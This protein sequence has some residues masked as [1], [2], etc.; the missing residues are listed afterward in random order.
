LKDESIPDKLADGF[1][2][3]YK[4]LY[5]KY[6]VDELYDTLFVNRIKGLGTRLARFDL[7]V[8]DG[9]VNGSAW[10]TRTI[11][12]ISGFFDYWFVDGAVRSSAII[13]YLS[14]PVRWLQTGRIQNYFAMAL[15]GMLLLT[16]YFLFR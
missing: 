8:I 2:G 1:E 5:S 16:V 11:A 10:M 9:G 3:V 6:W 4:T 13:Y 15:A 7:V 12:S 14:Y